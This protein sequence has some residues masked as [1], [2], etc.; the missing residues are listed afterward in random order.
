MI[1]MNNQHKPSSQELLAE[2]CR[3]T[4]DSGTLPEMFRRHFPRAPIGPS[5]TTKRFANFHE[6]ASHVLIMATPSFS[7]HLIFRYQAMSQWYREH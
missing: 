5:L 3:T 7:W 6:F 4:G 1:G 2:G